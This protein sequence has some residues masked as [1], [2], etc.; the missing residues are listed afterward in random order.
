MTYDEAG[1][2]CLGFAFN[3]DHDPDCFMV[4]RC[5]KC[6]RS[7]VVLAPNGVTLLESRP[8]I[9]RHVC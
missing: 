1:P 8:T 3:S 5:P 7:G 4:P 9:R 6:N 2:C